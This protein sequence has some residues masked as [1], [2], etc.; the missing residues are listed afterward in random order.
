MVSANMPLEEDGEAGLTDN[1]PHLGHSQ[2]SLW[3][4]LLLL[5]PLAS[6]VQ[7]QMGKC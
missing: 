3:W 4:M 2:G 1:H 7:L 6:A 5:T